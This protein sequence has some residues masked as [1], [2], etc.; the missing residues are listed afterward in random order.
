MSPMKASGDQSPEPVD[1]SIPAPPSTALVGPIEEAELVEATPVAPEVLAPSSGA[2]VV[3]PEGRHLSAW[4]AWQASPLVPVALKS[5]EL[6]RQ[7]AKA[8][9]VGLARSPFRTTGAVAR[10]AVIAG[11]AWWAW[12]RV[13][14][15]RRAA[16]EAD[17]LADRWAEIHDHAL[18][19][20]WLTMGVG[21]LVIIAALVVEAFWGSGPLWIAGVVIAAGLALAGRRRD[22]SPG[23]KAAL[24]GPRSLAWTMD[25]KILVDA[26]QDARLIGKDETL[27]L[28]QRAQRQGAG[29]AVVVDLPATRKATDVIRHREALASALAVDEVQLIVERVR[30][31][32]GHA[33][34][35]SL[36]VAD[37]D[38]YAA[39]P[40]PT[41]LL[42]A[43]RWDAWCPVPFGIDAR[44]RAI[45]LPLVWTSL[46]VG[47]IPRQ[48]KTFATRLAAAGL[49]LDPYPRL[50]IADGKGGKD[51][52]AAEAVAH[53]FI[54]GDDVHHA[55]ALRDVLV[56]LVC[57]VQA[58]FARMGQLSDELC[59]ESKLTPAMAKDRDL[60][61]PITAIVIDEVQVYL[62]NPTAIEV[63]GKRTTLGEHLA[64]LLT[65]LAKK[66]PAAGIVVIV[67]TQR[68]DA[69]T[70]PTRLR[71][72]LGSRFALR[73]M[74][75]RDSNI[76]LGDQMNTRGYDSSKLLASHK[77]VG[78]LRPDGETDAGADALALTVRTYFMPNADWAAICARGRVLREA[79]G[80]LS[81]HAAGHRAVVVADAAAVAKVLESNRTSATEPCDVELPEPLAAV[82]QYLAE[83]LDDH[84]GG[85][86]FIATAELAG[87]LEIDPVAF[88]AAMSELGCRSRH[89]RVV[90]EEGPCQV[91][92]YAFAD[93]KAAI[94]RARSGTDDEGGE[95]VSF[96]A[97]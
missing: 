71:A 69:K 48:G 85:R 36:W 80:T 51:W 61:M 65:Y 58:R 9:G 21:A 49:I 11:R 25:P 12:V 55:E 70:L 17:K 37:E 6:V 86:D 60:D 91:R 62:E 77:G 68:P 50:Y 46:L 23:R 79:A 15:Y 19:R 5:P 59:P 43:E 3:R 84:E 82:A 76:I 13:D 42:R 45:D 64:D 28:V 63:G 34:R 74:D 73:V 47:A 4:S 83:D 27:R 81:G 56:S 93:I 31:K 38:P 78:I 26:F 20:R 40:V 2:I 10:G 7:A 22:G 97:R 54:C 72:V 44:G 90:T 57:E 53:W 33:G 29:W 41:P 32:G 16:V 94:T 92:G 96:Y 89:G 52:R 75:W 39:E 8:A 67:A 87:A 14:D 18:R 1:A 35:V 30:G 88:S 24:A 66:G 95:V